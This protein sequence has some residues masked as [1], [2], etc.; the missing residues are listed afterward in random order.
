MKT[1]A[2]FQEANVCSGSVLPEL[3]GALKT[4][5]SKIIP[6]SALLAGKTI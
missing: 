4:T 1:R 3:A 6:L 2:A 5:L